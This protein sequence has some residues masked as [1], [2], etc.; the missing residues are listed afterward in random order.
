MCPSTVDGVDWSVQKNINNCK[1]QNEKV[2]LPTAHELRFLNFRILYA[3]WWF[4]ELK[5]V[6]FVDKY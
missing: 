6:E 2:K 3:W 1:E 5:D 4:V